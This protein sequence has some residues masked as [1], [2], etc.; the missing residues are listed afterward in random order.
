MDRCPKDEPTAKDLACKKALPISEKNRK[1]LLGGGG[2]VHL[3]TPLVIG[4]LK[5]YK[6]FWK[7]MYRLWI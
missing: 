3:P 2:G 7:T 4:G 6:I 5:W 1:N